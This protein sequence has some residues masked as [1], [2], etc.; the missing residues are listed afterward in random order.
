VSS[1]V[2]VFGGTFDPIHLGHLI[3][4]EAARRL[5]ALTRVLFVPARVPPHKRKVATP[6]EQRHHMVVLACA[7]NPHFAVSDVEMHRGGPSYTIETLRALGSDYPAGT[8][9]FLIMGADS[10]LEIAS[11]KDSDALLAAANVV[12]LGRPGYE[13][14]ELPTALADRITVLSTP[15]VEISSTDI[16]RLAREGE[17]IR[18]LVTDSVADYI[19]SAG[20]YGSGKEVP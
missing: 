16:R 2:G 7:D 20:L 5:L 4:A 6:P 9:F 8:E 13:L 19:R 18:Y 17:S 15:L 3:T 14:Q 10:V 11:W 1:R 12:V